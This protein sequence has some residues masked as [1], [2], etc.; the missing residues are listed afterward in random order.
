MKMRH[1]VIGIVLTVLLVLGLGHQW[2]SQ[3]ALK[4]PALPSELVLGFLEEH[5][6][7]RVR[8]AFRHGPNGWESLPTL[9]GVASDTNVAI[10]VERIEWQAWSEPPRKI[11]TTAYLE[12]EVYADRGLAAVADPA[13]IKWTGE[14]DPAFSGWR[15]VPVHRPQP[16]L[17]GSRRRLA[18]AIVARRVSVTLRELFPL[19]RQRAGVVTNCEAGDEQSLV[20]WEYGPEAVRIVDGAQFADSRELVGLQF[21]FMQNRCDGILERS[22][23]TFWFVVDVTGQI[24]AL[25]PALQGGQGPYSMYLLDVADIDGNGD[26]EAVFFWSGYNEDGYLLLHNGLRNQKVFSWQYH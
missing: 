6:E 11:R 17:A 8:L 24:S 16:V 19:F 7:P 2:R 10:S 14:P 20:E 22:W 12:S 5:D 4:R 1:A 18:S 9:M 25:E 3:A 13:S 26:V 23:S 15:Y 21:D